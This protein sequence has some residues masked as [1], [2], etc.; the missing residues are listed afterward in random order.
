MFATFAGVVEGMRVLDVGC[1]PGALTAELV[2]RLG[3]LA[4]AA[5]DPSDTFVA[6]ARV[7]HPAVEVHRAHAAQLP[8]EDETFDAALAQLVVP[9][10]NDPVAGLREMARVTRPRGILAACVW[11]HNDGRGPLG[12]F[13]DAAR[14]LDPGVEDESGLA[15]ARERRLGELF[16]EAGLHAIEESALSITSGHLTFDD[17]WEPFTLGVS[18]AGAYVAGLD[19]ARRDRLRDRCRAMLPTAPFTVTAR[20]WA[21]RGLV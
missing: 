9:V 5:V 8:F 4:V 11:D 7:R 3:P 13:W 16:H 17:W 14:D 15:G 21:A 6:A 12:P 18:P 10:M 1:G 2:N 19:L 20:A